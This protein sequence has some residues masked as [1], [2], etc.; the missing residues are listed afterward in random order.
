MR[1]LQAQREE[2]VWEH[3]DLHGFPFELPPHWNIAPTQSIALIRTPHQ[4]EFLRWGIKIPNPRA[5]GF[6]VRV[7]WPGAPF[8]RESIAGRRC[9]VVADGFYEWRVTGEGKSATKQPSL[10]KRQDGQPFAFAGFWA[11]VQ[12]KAEFVDAATILT[13]TPLGVA[14]QVHDR[15]PV[16]LPH[17]AE[18]AWLDR[19]A[20]YRDFIGVGRR[21]VGARGRVAPG[22]QREK[23]T[24]PSARIPSNAAH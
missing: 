5:G 1:S 14:A 19:K 16:I 12:V 9:P 17:D 3:F 8:Y 20:H 4:L 10:I 23:T 7:D 6:N 13:T 21:D 2:R 22:K 24:V 11:K 18:G 15:M